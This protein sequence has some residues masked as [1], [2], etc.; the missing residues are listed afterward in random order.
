MK[1]YLQKN[2]Y[3]AAIERI[4]Y[5]FDEFENILVAFSGGKDSSVLLNLCYDY[6][7][8]HGCLDKLAMYH[9]DYE[10]QYQMTTDF[11]KET[12][13]GFH[14]ILKFWLC[15]PVGA[16][17]ACRMDG[18]T[19]IPW[20]SAQ[21]EIWVRPMPKNEY[22]INEENCPFPIT[23]GEQDYAVQDRFTQCFADVHGTTGVMIGIRADE[24]LNRYRAIVS[25]RKVKGYGGKNFII[26]KSSTAHYCYPIYDWCVDDVWT[27]NATFF[28]P[29]NHI[30]DLYY[31]AGLTVDQMRVASPFHDCGADKLALYRAIDPQTWGK[32]VGRVNGVNMCAIYGGT[33]AMGRRDIEKP[34][35]FTWKEYCFFL[36]NT[37]P[38]G[39]RKHYLDKLKGSLKIWRDRGEALD[40]YPDDTSC[41]SSKQAPSYKR[42]CVCIIK[43]DYDCKYMGFAATK[44][45]AGRR[46][47]LMEKYRNL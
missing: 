14:G 15:L 16:R 44:K 40:D 20:D 11:V 22:V 4:E 28:K 21:K 31:Q 12:F 42:M 25:E 29:Y 32:M 17:C 37:L 41:E 1:T 45:E 46:K 27:Y 39:L 8:D 35:H 47:M 6:A 9:L 34:D 23:P 26:S 30:Y 2:V 38:D 18:D 13:D 10:A 5:C 3:E 19:W 7:I 36:L 24:S 43:N 33:S